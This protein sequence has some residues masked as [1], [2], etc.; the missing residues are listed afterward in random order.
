MAQQKCSDWADMVDIILDMAERWW[1]QGVWVERGSVQ[2]GLKDYL[3]DKKRQR[4]LRIPIHMHPFPPKGKDGRI[5]GLQPYFKQ[6]KYFIPLQNQYTYQAIKTK[7]GAVIEA[8]KTLDLSDDVFVPNLL[9]W[10]EGKKMA[11]KKDLLDCAGMGV[12]ILVAPKG[13]E[14]TEDRPWY[15]DRIMEAR[16][17]YIEQRKSNNRYY[18][19]AMNRRPH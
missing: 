13:A 7:E 4:G 10:R 5:K 14:T 8:G 15:Y 2:K 3:E 12:E 19:P 1:V 16:N 11:H 9:E 17:I 18:H 6:G